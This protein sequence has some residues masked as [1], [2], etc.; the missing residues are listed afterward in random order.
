MTLGGVSLPSGSS[1]A[2]FLLPTCLLLRSTQAGAAPPP[3]PGASFPAH[4]QALR[5][6][7]LGCGRMKLWSEG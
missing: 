2:G 3:Q 5:E 7:S 6:L 4:Q 1:P